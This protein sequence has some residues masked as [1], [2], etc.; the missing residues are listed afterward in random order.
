MTAI[1]EIYIRI[2][3]GRFERVPLISR[4]S[5]AHK[6]YIVEAYF[7]A[8]VLVNGIWQNS[9]RSRSDNFNKHFPDF[10]VVEQD[11][12]M[13]LAHIVGV[14]RETKFVPNKKGRT[15]VL[16]IDIH[17]RM[18]QEATKSSRRLA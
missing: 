9:V 18:E 10:A 7:R 11:F 15:E 6:T 1:M 12:E 8:G 13:C 2:V 4:S 14:Y 3:D 5:L 16:I 17:N